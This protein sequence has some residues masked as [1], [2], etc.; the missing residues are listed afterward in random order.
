LKK[1][2]PVGT[3]R[4][5]GSTVSE[6]PSPA[7]ANRAARTARGATEGSPPK[8]AFAGFA[9]GTLAFL[10][11]LERHNERAWLEAHRQDYERCYVEPA[12]AFV[13]A[14][15]P[16]LRRVSKTIRCEPRV[17]GSILRLQRDVR[18][19]KDKSPYRLTLDLLFWEGAR[20]GWDSSCL[21]FRLAAGQLTLGAGMHRFDKPMADA[22]RAAVLD[23]R[24]G[25]ALER[26]IAAVEG[27]GLYSVQGATR[28]KVPRGFDPDHPRARRLLHDGCY[29]LLEVP[30]PQE[31]AQASF[32]DY[33]ARH[34]AAMAPLHR[35][36]LTLAR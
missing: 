18:F 8:V 5:W 33:C 3:A 19:A 29:A 1:K 32:V 25:P 9:P 13:S 28:A 7:R 6:G 31:A 4:P 36:L 2:G 17:N 24:R 15:A 21:F 20:R 11:G 35:F 34:F 10:R 27:T 23:A 26:A 12:V 22:F 30:V 14:I 16:A